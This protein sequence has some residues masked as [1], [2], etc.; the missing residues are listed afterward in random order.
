MEANLRQSFRVLAEGRPKA[1]IAELDGVTIAS[2]GAAFQMFNA[3]FL[4]REVSG[5]EDLEKRLRAAR[6]VFDPRRIPWSFWICDEWLARP[7]RRDLVDTCESF[8]MRIVAEM[9][10]MVADPLRDTARFSLRSRPTLPLD[11]RRAEDGR[12]MS[13]FRAVG[14]LCFHVPPAWFGE[15]FDDTTPSREFRCWVGYHE[16]RPVATAA[17]VV[18]HGVIGLYNVAS[19]PGEQRRGFGEAITRHAVGEAAKESGLRRVIL[20]STSQGERLYRKLGFREVSRLVVF[21]SVTA[22]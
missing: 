18:S 3:A 8:G 1:D 22:V 9:P 5:P 13:D 20:Q 21:N 7:A 16:G 4:S 15:V 10:G 19:I 12:T 17:T 14:S 11:I 6:A 2:L